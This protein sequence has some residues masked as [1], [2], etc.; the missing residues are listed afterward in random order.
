MIG[1]VTVLW[2]F[3][4]AGTGELATQAAGENRLLVDCN[5]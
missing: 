3:T 1:L 2:P 5:V 4:T